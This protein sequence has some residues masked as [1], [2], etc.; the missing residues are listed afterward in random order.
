MS[1][2]TVFPS[3]RRGAVHSPPAPPS[4]ANILHILVRWRQRRRQRAA[5]AE[6]A[7]DAHLLKDI[8]LSREQALSEANKPFWR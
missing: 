5:L 1:T 3:S 6:L 7:D 2:T 8:G 4:L